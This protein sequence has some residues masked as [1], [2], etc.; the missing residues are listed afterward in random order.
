M[1]RIL[2][3]DDEEMTRSMLRQALEMKGHEVHEASNGDE[4]LRVHRQTPCPLVITD[5]LMPEKEGLETIVELR[6][7]HPELKIIAMSGG[8]SAG[9]LNFLEAAGKLGAQ[10]TLQKPFELATLFKTVDSL[11]DKESV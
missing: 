7:D 2:L 1:A 8:G 11:L 4:A 9:N 6:R 3:I 5:I 10:A